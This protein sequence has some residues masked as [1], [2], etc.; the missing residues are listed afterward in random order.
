MPLLSDLRRAVSLAYRSTSFY[1]HRY[2]QEPILSSITDLKTLPVTSNDDIRM[3]SDL[4]S[5]ITVEDVQHSHG[6]LYEIHPSSERDSVFPLTVVENE[7]DFVERYA[8]VDAILR[9]AKVDE[10]TNLVILADESTIYYAA[11]LE[12]LLLGRPLAVLVRN[13]MNMDRLADTLRNLVPEAIL[14]ATSTRINPA[15]IPRCCDKVIT[16]RGGHGFHGDSRFATY[17]VYCT[18]AFHWV[19]V[20][21]RLEPAYRLVRLLETEEQSRVPLYI[22]KGM[23]GHLLITRLAAENH[24]PLL[25][26]IRYDTEDMV[27]YLDEECFALVRPGKSL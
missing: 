15:V 7:G 25:P 21:E 19:A 5:C 12:R 2:K 18:H 3:T 8:R 22:E 16:L 11:D 14:I 24:V 13:H 1:K 17:D 26:L 10:E 9:Y 23:N 27:D 20:R 6:V 4:L